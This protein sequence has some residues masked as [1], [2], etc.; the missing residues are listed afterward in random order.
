MAGYT[1]SFY[2]SKYTENIRTILTRTNDRVKDHKKLKN[3]GHR[4]RFWCSQDEAH[5]KKAKPSQRPE[6]KHRDTIGMIRYPCRSRLSIKYRERDVK[7]AYVVIVLH[8]HFRH[9]HYLDVSM[10]PGATQIIQDQ[11]EWATPS[12][13]STQI[14]K[15]YPTVSAAQVYNTWK[16]LSEVH[17]RREDLQIPSAM[18]LLAEFKDE[19]DIF[20]PKDIPEGVEILAWGMKKIAGKLKGKIL[21][22]GMDATCTCGR[23][24]WSFNSKDG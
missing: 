1:V 17:W 20:R 2:V 9:V 15:M 14:R 13:L 16:D 24:F 22:V 8:H 12:V 4:S 18:K 10:P 3:N 7:D 23:N 11:S 19:V 21:E 5:K 6:A